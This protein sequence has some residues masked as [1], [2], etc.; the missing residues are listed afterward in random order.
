MVF[1]R[2]YPFFQKKGVFFN[3]F[4]NFRQKEGASLRVRACALKV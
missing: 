4:Q 3:F 2:F 1:N